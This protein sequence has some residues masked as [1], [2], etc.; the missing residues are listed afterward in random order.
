[1]VKPRSTRAPQLNMVRDQILTRLS[2]LATLSSIPQPLNRV[3]AATHG[4]FDVVL[5]ATGPLRLPYSVKPGYLARS[6]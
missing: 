3:P 5:D 4:F 1:M 6:R 2:K